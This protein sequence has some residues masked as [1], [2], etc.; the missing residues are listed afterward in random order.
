MMDDLAKAAG[1]DPVEFRLKHLGTDPHAYSVVKTASMKAGWGKPLAKG[2]SRGFAFHRSF[3][4]S[5]AM[6]AE[7]EL[8]RKTGKIKVHRVVCALDC[9]TVVNPE[10]VRSQIEGAVCFGLSA[11]LKERVEIASGGVSS[12]GFHNYDILRMKESPFIE[13]HLVKGQDKLGGIGEP[14]VPA[15]APAV[16]NAV[17]AS[18][19]VR[20]YDLPLSPKAILNGLKKQ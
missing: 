10:I 17:F 4:T 11:A 2:R 16:A 13:V 12:S 20:F 8:D 19:G 5:V 9:G 18:T 7:I 14:G 15:V 3:D 6:V 1:I